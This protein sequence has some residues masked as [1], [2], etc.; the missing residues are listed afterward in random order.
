MTIRTLVKQAER[1]LRDN[2]AAILTTMSV[3]GTVTTAYLAAKASFRAAHIIS[4]GE[5]INAGP[6]E[7]K[8]V[9]KA[10]WKLYIPATVSGAVTIG[11]IVAN[12]HINTRRT[13][14]A[15]SLLNV[16]ER[17]FAEYKDKVLEEIGPKKEQAV[18]DAIA[19]DKVTNNTS[20]VVA[21][22]GSVLCFEGHTG[23]YFMSDME[24]LKKAVNT[25]NAK[26]NREMEATLHDFQYLVGLP[27]TS[28]SWTVGWTSDR[29]MDL[30]F[31]TTISSDGKPCLV[32]EYNYLKQL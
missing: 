22:S 13:A 10:V 16:S 19:Q 28:Y 8:D 3:S 30:E 20:V 11:C 32:F 2:S 15:Y 25:I 6:V 12:T 18:R 29:L 7:R 23:R 4:E 21:G 9:V 27:D 26:L 5:R 1:L 17:A 14:V 31:S 24:T